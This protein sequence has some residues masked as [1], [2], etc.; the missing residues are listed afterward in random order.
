MG[1]LFGLLIGSSLG[2]GA[3]TPLPSFLGDIPLR[4]LAALEQSDDAYRA[5]R[6]LSIAGQVYQQYTATPNYLTDLSDDTTARRTELRRAVA[7]AM[8]WEISALHELA[9][10]KADNRTPAE[11]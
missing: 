6:K 3:A 8:N 11:R 4:C 7:D 5:C 1:F 2:S 9:K 10:A